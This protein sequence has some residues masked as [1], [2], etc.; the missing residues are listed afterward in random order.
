[1]KSEAHNVLSLVVVENIGILTK[2]K[3]SKLK[4]INRSAFG[5]IN[6]NLKI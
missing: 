2:L 5:N 3:K 6:N 4:L 1:M